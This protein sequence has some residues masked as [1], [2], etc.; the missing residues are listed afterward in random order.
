MRLV[1][2]AL[3]V[4]KTVWNA[5]MVIHAKSAEMT[6]FSTPLRKY[7]HALHRRFCSMVSAKPV[8]STAHPAVTPKNAPNATTHTYSLMEPVHSPAK[9]DI[10]SIVLCGLAFLVWRIVRLVVLL[11]NVKNVSRGLNMIRGFIDVWDPRKFRAWWSIKN[12]RL[13]KSLSVQKER[14]DQNYL[15]EV[16]KY[17]RL[18]VTKAATYSIITA[19]NVLRVAYHA[20]MGHHV[21]NAAIKLN[22]IWKRIAVFYRRHFRAKVYQKSCKSEFLPSKKQKVDQN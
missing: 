12:L 7:A 9:T 14:N 2:S 11:M 15:K 13:K 4:Q 6:R 10:Y 17:K 22:L 16:F 19:R 20:K 8:P 21:I 5:R 3:L 1:W 18:Y